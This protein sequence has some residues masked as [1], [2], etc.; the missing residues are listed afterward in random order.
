MGMD[1]LNSIGKGKP[2]QSPGQQGDKSRDQIDT[3]TP[4]ASHHSPSGILGLDMAME[5]SLL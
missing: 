2:D 4:A 3:S 5:E 1:R